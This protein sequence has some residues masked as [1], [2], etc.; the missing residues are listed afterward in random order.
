M[1]DVFDADSARAPGGGDGE[2]V[3]GLLAE[4]RAAERAGGRYIAI[5]ERRT[6]GGGRY[7]VHAARAARW[8]G[9]LYVNPV[10]V[11]GYVRLGVRCLVIAHSG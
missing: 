8:T 5:L 1:A 4:E 7:E 9:V 11:A 2:G 10:A 3:A 6:L